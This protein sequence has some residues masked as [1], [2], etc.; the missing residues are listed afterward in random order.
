MDATFADKNLSIEGRL[1]IL[2]AVNNLENPLTVNFPPGDIA[3]DRLYKGGV[4]GEV[5][6][7]GASLKPVIGGE[8][9]LED[10]EVSIPQSETPDR[11][12]TV[13]LATSKIDNVAAATR[14]PQNTNGAAPASSTSSSFITALNDLK[15]NLKDFKLEQ[16]PLYD[17]QLEGDLTLNGT[18]DEPS[19]IRPRG[20]LFLTR[21]DVDLFSNSFNAVRNRENTIVFSPQAGVFNPELDIILR[22]EVEDVDQQEYNQ[23]RSVDSNSNEI[24]DPLSETNNSQTIRINLVVDGDTQEILPNLGSNVSINCNI[25]PNNEPLVENER[26]YTEAE[27][28][29][30]TSCFNE[31]A[32]IGANE[33]NLI[34]SPAVELTSIPSLNQGEIINLLSGQFVAFADRVTNSSQSEL[35]NLGVSTFVIDPILDSFLYRVEDATVSLGKKINLD[36]FTVYPDLEAIYELNPDSSVRFT[37]SYN[38]FNKVVESINGNDNQETDSANEVKLEYQLNF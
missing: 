10:G 13:K 22:T 15:V 35:F 31:V 9:T 34:N 17:F 12:D 26:R 20:K 38:L 21:A 14:V 18:I 28:N 27:L 4:A 29:R 3:I 5:R 11:E 23:L 24:D 1:P 16:A 2:R 37:Y 8:V 32:Y 7:T 6:V 33:R 19:N 25:R 36:Y 30:F